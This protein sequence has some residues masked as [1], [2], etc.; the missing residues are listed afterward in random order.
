MTRWLLVAALLSV[1][2][3]SGPYTLGHELLPSAGELEPIPWFGG[4]D[5]YR[6]WPRGYPADASY[7]PIGVWMQ[8]PSNAERFSAVGVN[9]FVGLWEG[10]TDEQLATARAADM[11]V[12]CEQ[13]GVWEAHLDNADIQGWLQADGPDNA[14]ELPDG[15]YGPCIAP[16][17]T[18]AR[19]DEMVAADRSRP[20]MLLL[21]QGVAMPDWVGRGDCTGRTDDYFGYSESAD[22]LVNY[23]YPIANQNPLELVATGIEKLNTYAGWKKPVIADIEASSIEGLPRPTPEELR[24]EV[25]MSLIHGAAGIQYFCHRMTPLN[26]TDCL[27]DADT[28]TALERINRELLELAPVLNT[29]SYGLSPSSTNEGVP[30]RAVLKQLGGERYVFAAGMADGATTATFA[31]PGMGA[32]VDIEVIGENRVIVASGGSFEDAFEP[33]AVHLYRI[34]PG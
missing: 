25:W 1:G 6:D 17:A 9:H 18:R 4:P 19:Y 32:S 33:Y 31:L 3:D 12:V 8:N 30:V 14:Q 21:G 20:V 23:T 11:P 29:Q 27:D 26:E 22:I 28:A 13:A 16:A 15:S 2:C 34:P 10:P 5:Y 24:A 7:F